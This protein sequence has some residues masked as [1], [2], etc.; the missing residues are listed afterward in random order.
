ML[1]Y[2]HQKQEININVFETANFVV[3]KLNGFDC[4]EIVAGLCK[5]GIVGIIN[6]NLGE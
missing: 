1:R 6:D 5:T 4:D 2:L 3:G